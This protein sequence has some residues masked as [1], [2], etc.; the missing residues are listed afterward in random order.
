LESNRKVKSALYFFLHF[1]LWCYI[2][3]KRNESVDL[4]S[5]RFIKK[6]IYV[7]RSPHR[8]EDEVAVV[9]TG[10]KKNK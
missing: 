7:D 5:L 3:T 4:N 8:L 6:K 9:H 10:P 2:V 1:F